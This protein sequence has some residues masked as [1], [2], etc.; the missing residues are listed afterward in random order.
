MT[1]RPPAE[2]VAVLASLA[3]FTAL[4]F[5]APVILRAALAAL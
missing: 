5:F 4:M 2:V 3:A 1:P